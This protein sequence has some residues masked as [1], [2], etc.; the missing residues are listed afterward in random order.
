MSLSHALFRF[1]PN[2]IIYASNNL[3]TTRFLL[4]FH[5]FID[6]KYKKS[7]IGAVLYHG[8]DEI[9]ADNAILHYT[10]QPKAEFHGLLF[11]LNKAI[12]LHIDELYVDCES[13]F[14]INQ[15]NSIN[16]TCYSESIVPLYNKVKLLEKNF[17]YIQYNHICKYEN[18]RARQLAKS[19]MYTL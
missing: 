19:A 18:T 3:L 6:K 14:V 15:M 17:I 7:G 16:N 11:G 9:W 2:S 13:M 12:Q 1:N 5:G 8:H 10:N 4:R